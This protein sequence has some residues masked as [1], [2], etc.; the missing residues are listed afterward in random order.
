MTSTYSTGSHSTLG[1][2]NS[3]NWWFRL[4]G[5]CSKWNS[6][7]SIFGFAQFIKAYCVEGLCAASRKDTGG[8]PEWRPHR[9]ATSQKRHPAPDRNS[10]HVSRSSGP[11]WLLTAWIW[12]SSYTCFY[13]VEHSTTLHWFRGRQG[14]GQRLWAFQAGH[15]LLKGEIAQISSICARCRID[16]EWHVTRSLGA[17]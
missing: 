10:K 17:L 5:I 7:S 16:W 4:L 9:T 11:V 6:L 13:P 14:L 2:C 12:K 3:A 8:N 15:Q 1:S